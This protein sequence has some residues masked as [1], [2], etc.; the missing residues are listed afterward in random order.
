MCAGPD[1]AI[2]TGPW[3]PDQGGSA[4]LPRLVSMHVSHTTGPIARSANRTASLFSA[5]G[6]HPGARPSVPAEARRLGACLSALVCLVTSASSA[7]RSPAAVRGSA[8]TV[9]MREW[10]PVTP[11]WPGSRTFTGTV[12]LIA[13]VIAPAFT[14]VIALVFAPG[15]WR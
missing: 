14:P 1:S 5:T 9:A 13:P 3:Y 11:R 2:R 4:T 12:I 15:P 7:E 10:F 6:H 8:V